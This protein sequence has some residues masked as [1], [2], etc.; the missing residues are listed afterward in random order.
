MK[1]EE[2]QQIEF[3]ESWRDEY[4][5]WICGFANANGGKLY[6][7]IDDKGKITG[8]QDYKKLAEEIPN[9]T[10]DL[11]G[12]IIDVNIKKK[13]AKVYLEI[14][15]EPYP[16]PISYKGQ[17]HYRTGSTKQELKGAALDKFILRKQ[18]KH[19]DSVP[20][21]NIK[22]KDLNKNVIAQFKKTA[23]QL[24]K[25]NTP[26]INENNTITFQNLGL[27]DG[28]YLNRT[29]ALF[30][31]NNP[32]Q[33]ITG[34]SIKIGYFKSE[35]ELLFQDEITG[36]LYE[37]VDRAM[38]LLLTKYLKAIISY[39]GINR[40]ET[41]LYPE[42][43]LREA[44]LNAV[45]H[46]D[47]SSGNPIQISVYSDKLIIFNAGELPMNWT[48]NNL[49][50]KH[51]SIPF[52]PLISKMFFNYGL[53]EAWGSGTMK[54]IKQCTAYG[55]LQPNFLMDSVGLTIEFYAKNYAKLDTKLDT[56]PDTKL[57]TKL[58]TKVDTNCFFDEDYLMKV[59]IVQLI[60][61]NKDISVNSMVLHLGKSKSTILRYIAKLKNDGNIIREGNHRIGYWRIS[62][63]KITRE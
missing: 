31:Y 2:N 55:V 5:K 34:A 20:L 48:V 38:N 19:W 40:K 1:K 58:D 62:R 46:K 4:V 12:I 59:K 39:V 10:R 22:F 50:K 43:A 54:I 36:T 35:G 21:P 14:I 33:I 8:V 24:N 57:D 47:Y 45:A 37:Q 30:F 23:V 63:K 3:K 42:L 16:F 25:L 7:G 49:L 11:L 52:N 26:I 41:Y 9:K 29:A 61:N 13:L 60:R 15:V 32:Q 51:V 56:R 18:G 6:I 53:I 44:L 17:Y 28:K 27:Y